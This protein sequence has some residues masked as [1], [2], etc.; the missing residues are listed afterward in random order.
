M[1]KHS[2]FLLTHVFVF[3][4]EFPRFPLVVRFVQQ[5]N[6]C[7]YCIVV[8]CGVGEGISVQTS[9][10]VPKALDPPE[11]SAAG[12]TVIEVRW[13]P[14]RKPNGLITGY[15]LYRYTPIAY[16]KQT[17]CCLFLLHGCEKLLY[18]MLN[19]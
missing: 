2:G 7:T 6:K 14:P 12:A 11:L 9:E 5:K 15:F 17:L 8:C 18:L 3:L 13:S 16:T 10:A 1:T 19:V 4:F